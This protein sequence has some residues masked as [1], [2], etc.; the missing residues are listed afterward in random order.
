MSSQTTARR[1]VT[2]LTLGLTILAVAPFFGRLRDLLLELMPQ[3]F[4]SVLTVGFVLVL[5][6]AGLFALRRVR[7]HLWWRLGAATLA[8]GLV[9]LQVVVFSRGPASVSAV[10]RFHILEY[11]LLAAL[12]YWALRP[13]GGWLAV[14]LA[15]ESAAIFGILDETVQWLVPTRVGE[16]RDILLNWSAVGVGLIAAVSLAL[17]IHDNRGVRPRDRARMRLGAFAG[18]AL[19]I[20]LS[21]GFFDMAHLG[22]RI[23]DRENGLT[24]RSWFPE[25]RLSRL[26]ALRARAWGEHAPAALRPLSLEDYYLT[27]GTAHVER[28]NQA[29]RER[30][31][32]VAAGEERVLEAWYAPVLGLRGLASGRPLSLSAPE[33]RMLRR[34]DAA[35]RQVM[36]ESSVLADRVFVRPSRRTLWATAVTLSAALMAAALW[37]G[38][39]RR[40][41]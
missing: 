34:R 3:A 39:V 28:R 6:V 18:L 29:L 20:L 22:Y 16:M 33:L 36:F 31:L 19:L 24:F 32:R 38:A 30:N 37:R 7:D 41:G 12:F 17:P 11:G 13:H 2:P 1:L 4:T 27:E 26:D 25:E 8:V 21:T 14:V 5:V 9:G 35:S 23:V 15:A 10:E 40:R